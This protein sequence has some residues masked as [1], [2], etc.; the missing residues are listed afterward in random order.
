MNYRGTSQAYLVQH[1]R[2]LI[3]L[4]EWRPT[5][6]VCSAVATVDCSGHRV[7]NAAT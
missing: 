3:T 7:T 1:V 4:P 5:Q 6:D 2:M